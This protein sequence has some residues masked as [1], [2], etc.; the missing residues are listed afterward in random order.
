MLPAVVLLTVLSTPASEVEALARQA[1]E[2]WEAE[3]YEESLELLRRANSI[4]PLPVLRNNLGR[5][6]E[7]LG[8]YEEAAAAY[9]SVVDDDAAPA[10]LRS[11]DRERLRALEPKLGRAWLQIDDLAVL[12]HVHVDG[13]AVSGTRLVHGVLE[14]GVDPGARTI[15]WLL[16]GRDVVIRFLDLGVG[17]TR[18]AARELSDARVILPN[19]LTPPIVVASYEVQTSKNHRTSALRVAPGRYAVRIGSDALDLELAPS[20]TAVWHELLP[21]PPPPPNLV[22]A[23]TPPPKRSSALPWVGLGVGATAGVIGGILLGAASAD[24]SAVTDA[25]VTT[26]VVEDV[27]YARAVQLEGRAND[28]ETAGAVLI[29]SGG[30]VVIGSL[31]WWLLE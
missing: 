9:R 30:A 24:R 21:R 26:A 5:A 28:R 10:T 25:L 6:L 20:Q 13:V 18:I 22:A 11:L 17:T 12:R 16:D 23:P 3:R 31:V 27:T 1:L 2:A 29:A 15:E 19:P 4:S 7:Q 8:R 14:F